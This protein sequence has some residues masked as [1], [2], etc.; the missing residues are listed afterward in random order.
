MNIMHTYKKIVDANILQIKNERREEYELV[1]I[2]DT[3]DSI[4]IEKHLQS[5]WTRDVKNSAGSLLITCLGYPT[6]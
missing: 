2:S 3:K 4:R 6:K 5:C 1:I